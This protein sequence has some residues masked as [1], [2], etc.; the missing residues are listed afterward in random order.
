MWGLYL[1]AAHSFIDWVVTLFM[2]KSVDRLFFHY[3]EAGNI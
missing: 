2:L 1:R 3:K